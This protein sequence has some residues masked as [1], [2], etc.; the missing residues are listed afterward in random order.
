MGEW[1]RIF[2]LHVEG[3][4][5]GRGA[6]GKFTRRAISSLTKNLETFPMCVRSNLKGALTELQNVM[7]IISIPI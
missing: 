5:K 1:V 6:Q 4:L 7:D 2:P 3:G